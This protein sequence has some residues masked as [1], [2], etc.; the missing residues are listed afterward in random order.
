MVT[1]YRIGEQAIKILNAGGYTTD[2]R[3]TMQHAS[4]AAQECRNVAVRDYIW[5]NRSIGERNVPVDLLTPYTVKSVVEGCNNI[6][7]LPIKTLSDLQND[8]SIFTVRLVGDFGNYLVP[9]RDGFPTMYKNLGID[10]M[11]GRPY[12]MPIGNKLYVYGISEA[13]EFELQ[14]IVDATQL[15]ARDDLYITP[16]ME[17]EIVKMTAQK[18][19]NTTVGVQ[20]TINDNL[21]E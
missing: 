11:E 3:I 7:T 6:I 8:F 5:Q 16:A 15:E 1:A 20:D 17:G 10:S 12:Y 18:L 13:A 21:D 14:L 9:V 19:S 2:S 4:L